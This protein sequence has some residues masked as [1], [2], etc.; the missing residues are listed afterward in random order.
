MSRLSFD[1]WRQSGT[2]LPEPM[3]DFHDQ[4]DLFKAMD[5]VRERS[6]AKNGGLHMRD[7]SW[8]D[9]HVY[10]VDIFLWVMA[11]H[12]YTLQRSR[13]P[14]A[15]GDLYTFMSDARKRWQDACAKILFP[16]AANTQTPAKT[17]AE[18]ATVNAGQVPGTD[19]QNGGAA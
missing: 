19:H 6:I 9:C 13:R 10:T 8:S 18:V 2:Y 17:E 15:F 12:G 4:K 14:F 7:R 16:R 3:R 11:G 5:E 1:E